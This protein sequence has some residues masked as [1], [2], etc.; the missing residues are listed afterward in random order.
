MS[1]WGPRRTLGS[2]EKG[3]NRGGSIRVMHCMPSSR[4][5]VQDL[6]EAWNYCFS[7]STAVVKMVGHLL[8]YQ[9]FSCLLCPLIPITAMEW[10]SSTTNPSAFSRQSWSDLGEV[11]DLLSHHSTQRSPDH[12]WLVLP[13][14][15]LP[16]LK[17]TTSMSKMLSLDR[18]KILGIVLRS[19]WT[20]FTSN[21]RCFSTFAEFS[22]TI[23]AVLDTDGSEPLGLWS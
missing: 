17:K 23:D 3:W 5:W 12:I 11:S 22:H 16:P 13:C 9:G 6:W 1:L 10:C 8:V 15:R 19:P 20:C 18:W 21:Y 4:L 2:P 7:V 14:I